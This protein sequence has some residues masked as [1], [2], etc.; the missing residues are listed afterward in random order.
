MSV[1]RDMDKQ[2]TL[3]PS[4][5]TRM[6]GL[7]LLEIAGCARHIASIPHGQ[8]LIEVVHLSF[9]GQ[10]LISSLEKEIRLNRSD[11]DRP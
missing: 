9:V 11:G 7:K 2:R 10:M 5:S 1:G 4:S 3:R 8:R 6:A